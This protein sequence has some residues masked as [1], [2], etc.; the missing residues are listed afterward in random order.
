MFTAIW[1]RMKLT[2]VISTMSRTVNNIRRVSKRR[3]G[4]ELLFKDL[5]DFP[6]RTERMGKMEQLVQLAPLVLFIPWNSNSKKN[7]LVFIHKFVKRI[8]FLKGPTGSTGID[9]KDAVDGK[10]GSD[11]S[12][13]SRWCSRI[14]WICWNPRT[15]YNLVIKKNVQYLFNSLTFFKM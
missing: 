1:L 13:W 4:N 6:G 10:D 11:G 15:R 5:L 14:C 3:N 7:A 12:R 8:S 9:G 2:V